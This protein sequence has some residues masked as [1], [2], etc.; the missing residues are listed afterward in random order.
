MA[1]PYIPGR[2]QWAPGL[3]CP[4]LGASHRV[5]ALCSLVLGELIGP[6]TLRHLGELN[7]P[8]A[9]HIPCLCKHLGELLGPQVPRYLGELKGP[10]AVS[11]L[12]E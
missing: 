7:G 2:A 10:Q 11:S 1:A 6:Q 4:H 12:S 8:Q 5:Q 3:C 9:P